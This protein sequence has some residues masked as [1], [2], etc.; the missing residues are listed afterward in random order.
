MAGTRL[1]CDAS[2]DA[3]GRADLRPRRHPLGH[4]C[5]LRGRVPITEADL[6]GVVGKPHRDAVR[7]V[8]TGLSEADV[9]RISEE[10]AREDNRAIAERG[11]DLYPGVREQIPELGRRLPLMI[12]SNCQS[13]YIEIFLEQSGL[14]AHFRDRECWGNTGESK[15]ANL[16][17]VI[18]RNA[19]L[20]PAFIG[21]TDGDRRAARDNRISFIHAAYGFGGVPEADHRIATFGELL[22]L[23]A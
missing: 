19:L 7:K 1:P 12:V 9:L 23:L 8:F 2:G 6:H 11:G 14:G 20:R 18:Q 15:T 5:H 13:G 16:R 10:T 17:A 21:D 3:L 22:P 4:E